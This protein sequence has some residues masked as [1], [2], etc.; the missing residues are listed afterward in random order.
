MRAPLPT[1]AGSEEGRLFSQANN[2]VAH[3]KKNDNIDKVDPDESKSTFRLIFL[4]DLTITTFCQPIKFF[5]WFFSPFSLQ[6]NFF[7]L[8]FIYLCFQ[9][10]HVLVLVE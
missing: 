10:S 6:V 7:S 9:V 5:S 3:T 2:A 8:L 4:P 1:P